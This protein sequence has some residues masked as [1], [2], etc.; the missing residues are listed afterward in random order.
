MRHIHRAVKG[1]DKE[2]CWTYCVAPELCGKY[3][4]YQDAHGNI[5]RVDV[6]ACG[7]TRQSEINSGRTNYGEWEGEGNGKEN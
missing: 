5:V 3:P 4:E 6:C 7:A 1:K 2:R